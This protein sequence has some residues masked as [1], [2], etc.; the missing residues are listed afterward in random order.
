MKGL[1]IFYILFLILITVACEEPTPITFDENP[2]I[3]IEAITPTTVKE[4]SEP[5]TITIAYKDGNGD[6]GFEDP[7]KAVVYI[8]DARLLATDTYHLSPRAPLN[9]NIPIEGIFSI[10]LKNTFILGNANQETT[11]YEI[12]LVDRAGNQSNTVTTQM[13]TITR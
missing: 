5:I 1:S 13:I 3:V 7:D 4:F 2:T 6:L 11:N 12:Y 10:A 9:S 8:K